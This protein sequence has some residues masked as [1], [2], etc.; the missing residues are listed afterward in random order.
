MED[1]VVNE[2]KTTISSSTKIDGSIKAKEH[3][4]INGTIKGNVD[5]KD[6]NL[7]MGPSGIIEGDVH[8]QNV[9]IRGDM[10]GDIKA[11]GKVE[12]TKEG[13]FSGNIE[14]K[15]IAVEQ[16]AYLDAFVNLGRGVS[17]TKAPEETSIV[18]STVDLSSG[19][20]S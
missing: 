5:I 13:N 8:A 10:K 1:S 3:L 15:S 18:K 6:Y 20:N 17:E 7:F 2:A 4:I 12:I 11:T 19:K 14:S 16:G 9:R